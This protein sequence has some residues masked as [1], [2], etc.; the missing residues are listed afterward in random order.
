MTPLHNSSCVL[1]GHSLIDHH[2]SSL[3]CQVRTKRH[4]WSRSVQCPCE[5]RRDHPFGG[6]TQP[7]G[8]KRYMS[9]CRSRSTSRCPQNPFAGEA[10]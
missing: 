8:T 4:W 7:S 6:L 9:P 1:C 10:L 5:M 2:E 3:R